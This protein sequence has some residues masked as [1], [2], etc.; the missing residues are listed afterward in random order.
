MS[1]HTDL[2]TLVGAY[3]LHALPDDEHALFEAHLRDCRACAE[4]AE[5]L[6]ATATKLAAAITSPPAMS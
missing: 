3:S 2:H 4:E 5:N 6:T 1:L